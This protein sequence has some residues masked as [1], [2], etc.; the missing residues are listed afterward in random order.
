MYGN[1]RGK[2]YCQRQYAI[3]Y[4]KSIANTN[5]VH[6]FDFTLIYMLGTV[7]KWSCTY[8]YVK[9]ET[10]QNGTTH[11]QQTEKKKH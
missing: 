4:W 8:M 3:R 7:S 5:F 1:K 10:K 2:N 9:E 6:L 11:K